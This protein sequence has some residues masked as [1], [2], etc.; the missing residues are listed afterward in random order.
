METNVDIAGLSRFWS[1]RFLAR[2]LGCLGS[3]SAFWFLEELWTSNDRVLRCLQHFLTFFTIYL[4]AMQPYLRPQ[5]TI[6]IS[7]S[8]VSPERMELRSICATMGCILVRTHANSLAALLYI[9][10]LDV[11]R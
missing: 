4:T 11:P 7:T 5:F 9:Y 10:I 8:P 3:L 2:F 6:H 1:L